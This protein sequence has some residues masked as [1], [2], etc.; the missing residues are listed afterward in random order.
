MQIKDFSRQMAIIFS[1][2]LLI[3]GG[4]VAWAQDTSLTEPP[5]CSNIKNYLD[6]T[7]TGRLED[8]VFVFDTTGSM[9]GEIAE[10]QSAVIEF[11]GTIATA[12]IDYS[13]GL[14]EYETCDVNPYNVYNNGILTPD[15]TVMRDWIQ[16]LTATGGG[17]ESVLDAL[18]HAVS[19][20]KWRPNSKRIIILIGDEPPQCSGEGNTLDSVISMLR[21]EGIVTHVIGSNEDS[22]HRIASETGGSFFEIRATDSF[23]SI[24]TSIAE[25]I[26]CTFHTHSM[27]SYQEDMLKI[28]TKLM[29]LEKKTIPHIEGEFELSVSVCRDDVDCA[30]FELTP[31]VTDSGETNY[32]QTADVSAFKDTVQLTDLAILIKGCGYATSL[33]PAPLHIGDC[34]PEVTPMPNIPALEVLVDGNH[35][36]AM[37]GHDPYANGYTFFY[38][39]YS[40]PIGPVTLDNITSISMGFQ[41]SI[42]GELDSGLKLYTAVQ[43]YN[44]SGDSDYSNLGV[45]DI[46]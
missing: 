25:L 23:T 19:D 45:V 42:E 36:E 8:I 13:L 10:M 11:A 5:S 4:N 31:T 40:N 38:V 43:A 24:I 2:T 34:V 28:E 27:F 29:G 17:S 1:S 46:P 16:S 32:Q 22:M 9:D 39:P 15:E 41:T 7:S 33:P 6:C 44:C 21:G 18:A 35:A 3:C 12:G 30:E 37:W 26:S 20:Y 14:T